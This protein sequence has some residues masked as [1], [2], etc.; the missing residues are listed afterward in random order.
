MAHLRVYTGGTPGL[1]DGTEIVPG[2]NY[3]DASGLYPYTELVIPICLR[4]DPG[5]NATGVAVTKGS[6]TSLQN[7]P[8]F[9][10]TFSS[11]SAYQNFNS[12]GAMTLQLSFST[13]GNTNIMFL[14]CLVTQSITGNP[15]PDIVDL[16]S[17]SFTEVIV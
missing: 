4:C 2:T 8:F 13:I 16:F 15:A 5:F 9:S 3:I 6:N 10:T 17:V 7:F 14:L 11:L 12:S 1:A